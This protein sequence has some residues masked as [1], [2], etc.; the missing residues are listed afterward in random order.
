M[1]RLATAV[2]LLALAAAPALA[3]ETGGCGAFAWPIEPDK[4]LLAA[5]P[6]A[7]SGAR[8]DLPR[9]AAVRLVLTDAAKA[10]FELPPGKPAAPSAPA[11]VLRFEARTG[12]YQITTTERVWIDAAQAGR[13]L[14]EVGFSG[15]LDCEGARKSVRF[16]LQ[17]GPATIQISGSP[18][19]TLGIAV[20]ALPK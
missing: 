5:A 6:M 18:S 3:A 8:L 14:D 10:G 2:V 12:L 19:R 15:V 4:A 9:P 17:D 7:E 16:Q 20:T 11:G 1:I 13:L